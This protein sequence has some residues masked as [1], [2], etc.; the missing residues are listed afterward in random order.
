MDNQ[1]FTKKFRVSLARVL[2]A[3]GE[4]CPDEARIQ[5]SWSE[6]RAIFDSPELV[7]YRKTIG[8]LGGMIP[9]GYFGKRDGQDEYHQN[10]RDFL[11]YWDQSQQ[12][13]ASGGSME[14]DMSVGQLKTSL[15]VIERNQEIFG[16]F[17]SSSD[18]F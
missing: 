8:D 9:E 16:K 17:F 7:R 1:D 3:L 6:A 4:E 10:F 5:Q 13:M 2:D 11:A 18:H 12:A 14:R 15:Q